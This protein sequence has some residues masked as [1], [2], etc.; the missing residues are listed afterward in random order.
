MA[1]YREQHALKEKCGTREIR[2]HSRR[3][4]KT[5]RI[6]RVRKRAECSGSPRGS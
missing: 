3:P 5:A 2:L 4:A 1:G 6:S